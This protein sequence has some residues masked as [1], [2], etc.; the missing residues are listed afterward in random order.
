MNFKSELDI[1]ND[2]F[3]PAQVRSAATGNG[4][5]TSM[6]IVSDQ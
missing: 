4:G 5:V 1:S 2:S 3:N 6:G